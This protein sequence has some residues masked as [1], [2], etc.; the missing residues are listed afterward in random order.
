M[1]SKLP[2]TCGEL[3][4][5]VVALAPSVLQ[6]QPKSK[7]SLCDGAD[8]IPAD[9]AEQFCKDPYLKKPLA[10]LVPNSVMAENLLLTATVIYHD[11]P[12]IAPG[13]EKTLTL[14]F[15]NKSGRDSNTGLSTP[16]NLT[17]RWLGCENLSVQGRTSVT[18]P[19]LTP[20]S[21]GTVELTVTVR[22]GERV[23][24][25]NRLVLEILNEGMAQILY[26]P[27]VF[28]G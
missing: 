15:Y 10:R 12:E 8:E 9:I 18:V 6:A 14:R 7:V 19:H 25:V 21:D 4:D 3:T 11:A 5:R 17:L 27:V 26:L 20:H 23:E 1:G 16:H 2:K 13:E 24:P 28:L 22:A